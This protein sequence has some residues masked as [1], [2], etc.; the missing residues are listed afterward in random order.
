ME[1][2]A[3]PPRVGNSSVLGGPARRGRAGGGA[4]GGAGPQAAGEGP[5]E[6]G[7][8]FSGAQAPAPGGREAGAF[9]AASAAAFGSPQP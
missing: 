6:A 1:G 8:G 7:F 9:L 2:G 5:E 4:D 3:G